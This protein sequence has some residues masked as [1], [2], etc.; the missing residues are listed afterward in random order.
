MFLSDPS[1]RARVRFPFAFRVLLALALGIVLGLVLG[2][3][4]AAFTRVGSIILDLI[5]ALAAPLLFLAIVDAFLRTSIRGRGVAVMLIVSLINATLA[6]LI[7]LLISNIL[8]PGR[9]L[10]VPDLAAFTQAKTE[11]GKLAD[12][13]QP[14]RR[15]DFLDD[16]L[17]LI[18]SSVAAPWVDNQL[19]G[20]VFLAV[21][22]GLALRAVKQEQIRTGQEGFEILEG[23]VATLFRA[24]EILIGW[25]IQLVPLAVFSVVSATVGRFGLAPLSGLAVYV[26]VGLLGLAIQVFMVYQ[27]WI[28][29]AARRPLWWFWR[30]CQDAL[31]NA[32]GTGSSL[33]TLPVTLRCLDRMGVSNHAARISACVGTNLNNDGILLYEA[34]A[35]LFVAQACGIELSLGQQAIAAFG[36]V[37][38]G[39]GISG[40]PEAGLISLLLVLRTVRIVPDEM[41]AGIVPLLL[42]VDWILGRARAATNVASDCLVAVVIDRFTPETDQDQFNSGGKI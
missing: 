3:R 5:K 28:V 24:A 7:G 15:I 34:M 27:L 32:L 40:I 21:L 17:R 6:I 25:V 35:V 30:G 37:I 4:M 9:S 10:S 18:P 1:L 2:E 36:C 33:A 20:L 12:K 26:S 31:T 11:Y 29:I 13:V 42:T 22:A 19:I 39:V 8:H 16:L 14:G 38:A 23:L 41:I